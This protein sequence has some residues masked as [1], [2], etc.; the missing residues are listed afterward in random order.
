MATYLLYSCMPGFHSLLAGKV[1]DCRL[2][3]SSGF[4]DS[5]A[6]VH[7]CN[8]SNNKSQFWFN[9]FLIPMLRLNIKDCVHGLWFVTFCGGFGI[10][11]LYSYVY[12]LEF[13]MLCGSFGIGPLYPY[14]HGLGFAMFVVVLV[15]VLH[16]Y[17]YMVWD[18][19]CLWW[20]LVLVLHARMYMVWD[21][22]CLWWFWYWSFMPVCTWFGI[23]YVCGG[24]D[25]G[26]LYP[27]IHGLGFAMFV[28]VLVLVLHTHMYMVW[29]LL[30]LWWFW[31]RSLI[32]IC[33]RFGSCY[34]LWCFFIGPWYPYVHGL[35]LGY[36]HILEVCFSV[37]VK[38]R[39]S[40]Q[41]QWSNLSW[42]GLSEYMKKLQIGN[43]I[44]RTQTD[45][46][47]MFMGYY[48]FLHSKAV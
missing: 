35:G 19:L 18:L 36:T 5:R 20:F 12:G 15:L 24:F 32:L 26:P 3:N 29:D 6:S 37:T 44:I 2:L 11:P 1:K 23:C 14:A 48:V 42:Y 45:I 17:M 38:I 13:V 4:Q 46:L 28:V 34:A 47:C 25:L 27:D 21:L 31:S 33:T 30:Y 10:C 39:R 40:V 9:A 22:L 16:T 7:C 41:C 8:Q 43:M